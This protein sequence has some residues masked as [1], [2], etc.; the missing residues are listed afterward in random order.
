MSDP[1]K[2]WKDKDDPHGI[3]TALGLGWLYVEACKKFL[4]DL[5]SACSDKD[6]DGSTDDLRDK[7][8]I[9]FYVQDY[10]QGSD[11]VKND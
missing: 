9:I 6:A 5:G 10:G 2:Y 11:K 7:K 8:K 3:K 1:L 4:L